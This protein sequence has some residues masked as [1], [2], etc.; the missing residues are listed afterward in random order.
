MP[1]TWL[2]SRRSRCC[3][4]WRSRKSL[5]RV[6]SMQLSRIWATFR[7]VVSFL[8]AAPARMGAA[9]EPLHWRCTVRS[10][11]RAT[12]G[13]SGHEGCRAARGGCLSPGCRHRRDSSAQV[14][15]TSAR[16]GAPS[17]R[18]PSQARSAREAPP[19]SCRRARGSRCS[20]SSRPLATAALGLWAG[21]RASSRRRAD[22]RE[23]LGKADRRH[24]VG[25]AVDPDRALAARRRVVDPAHQVPASAVPWEPTPTPAVQRHSV[26][27]SW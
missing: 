19:R 9:R 14:S 4:A 6:D 27:R 24:L 21:M 23:V 17:P 13:A 25:L 2:P 3:G 11:R 10:A 18:A 26:T 20:T 15:A 22:A 7:S 12:G 1:P 8:A 16:G 5:P